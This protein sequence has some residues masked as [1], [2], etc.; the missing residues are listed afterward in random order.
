MLQILNYIA[1]FTFLG[2]FSYLFSVFQSGIN[3]SVL[4]LD[5]VCAQQKQE[6]ES[7][8]TFVT[9]TRFLLLKFGIER[10]SIVWLQLGCYDLCPRTIETQQSI[11]C[12]FKTIISRFHDRSIA[13]SKYRAQSHQILCENFIHLFMLIFHSRTNF[14]QNP[15]EF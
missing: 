5:L 3:K 1:L 15:I 4:P 2:Q 14:N 11:R 8:G 7:T 13:T 12:G 6:M 9:V 10:I